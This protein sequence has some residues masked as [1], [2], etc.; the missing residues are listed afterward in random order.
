MPQIQIKLGPDATW[1]IP[2]QIDE[3]LRAALQR[4]I[5]R[6]AKSEGDSAWLDG[7][8][9]QI[10]SAI[11]ET[12]DWDLQRPLPT[13]MDMAAAIARELDIPIPAAAVRFRGT[14][15]SYIARY[16]PRYRHSKASRS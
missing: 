12:L 8:T 14:M 2:I 1:V 3:G 16:Q 15:A 4:Q 7:L 6:N 9:S 13:Q 11:Y 10:A 5:E